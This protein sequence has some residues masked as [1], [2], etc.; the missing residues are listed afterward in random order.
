MSQA[1]LAPYLTFDGNC[2]E[3]MSFYQQCLGGELE[4]MP[5]AEAPAENIPAG[6]EAGIMHACLTSGPLVLMASD[7]YG[8]PI[9][10]GNNVT[11]SLHCT[12]REELTTRFEQLG[13]GG[14]VTM[15]LEET[16]WGATL[17]MVTDQY[18]M[19]WLLDF[20]PN[21]EQ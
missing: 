12:S 5:F 9:V 19:H 14:Q 6:S 13:A 2:R 16:F 8:Q 11:L 18:G 17:G 20:G 15:P 3:A 1:T 21:P 7:G 4:L 10:P